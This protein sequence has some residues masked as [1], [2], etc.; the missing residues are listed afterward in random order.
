[1]K[2]NTERINIPTT[3]P[4][5]QSSPSKSHKY[6]SSLD[7]HISNPLD[8]SVSR[9]IVHTNL[10]E[11]FARKYKH[12]SL[13]NYNYLRKH[14]SFQNKPFFYKKRRKCNNSSNKCNK[15]NKQKLKITSPFNDTRYISRK[16]VSL[17]YFFFYLSHHN[18]YYNY[19]IYMIQKIIIILVF[20]IMIN[21]YFLLQN[22]ILLQ[23]I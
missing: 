8:S 16:Q 19:S 4:T 23:L 18:F 3:S 21:L 13:S 11:I 17:F 2:T 15:Y 7:K 14:K 1:M 9:E 6:L 22:V 10:G 20:H 12:Y 5:R